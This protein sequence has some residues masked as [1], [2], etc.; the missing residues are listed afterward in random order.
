MLPQNAAG[1]PLRDTKTLLD[2]DDALA[3]AFGA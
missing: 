3:A 2:M 1:E